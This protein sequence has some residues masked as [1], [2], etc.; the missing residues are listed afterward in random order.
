M[1]IHYVMVVNGS[2]CWIHNTAD[3]TLALLP[4]VKHGCLARF[5]HSTLTLH[6]VL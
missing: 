4:M 3:L 1:D 5:D 2:Y 6:K